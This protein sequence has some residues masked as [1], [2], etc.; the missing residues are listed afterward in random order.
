MASCPVLHSTSIMSAPSTTS[1]L[2]L[3]SDAPYVFS[4]VQGDNY[5]SGEWC[6]SNHTAWT[7]SNIG[8]LVAI[9]VRSTLNGKLLSQV[10]SWSHGRCWCCTITLSL[11]TRRYDVFLTICRELHYIWSDRVDLDVRQVHL[12]LLIC[13]DTFWRLRWRL[14]KI[15]FLINR[16]VLTLLIVCVTWL[17]SPR[18]LNMT[19]SNGRIE[20]FREYHM[21]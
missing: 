21:A 9:V 3:D 17:F 12:Y 6:M 2:P 1:Y 15:I 13:S 16:Y 7:Q 20:N 4:L 14:P 10:D 5:V 18:I 19:C 11:L 8:W